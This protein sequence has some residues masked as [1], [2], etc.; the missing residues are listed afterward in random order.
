MAKDREACGRCSLSV[1]VDTANGD[2]D[3]DERATRDPY[4]EDSI[5][6]DE[7]E[8]KRLSPDGWLSR[9]ADRLD[10]VATHLVWNR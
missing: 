6:V 2:R 1:V 10:T 8:L 4:G 9:V 7:T 3:A 5:E